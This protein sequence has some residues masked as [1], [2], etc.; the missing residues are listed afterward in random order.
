[1][2]GQRK[3]MTERI[4]ELRERRATLEA[5]GGEKRHA[6]GELRRGDRLR[7]RHLGAQLAAAY[8]MRVR[9]KGRN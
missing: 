9:T 6:H 5:G 7:A 1:M 8:V 2:T 3:T 4:A